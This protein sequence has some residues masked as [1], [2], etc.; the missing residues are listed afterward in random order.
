MD[1]D[2]AARTWIEAWDRAWRTLDP[3]PLRPVY[4]EN[5]VHHSHPFREPGSPL[6]YA[7]WAFSDEEGEPELW[8]GEPIVAGDRAV[9]EWWAVSRVPA[10]LTS[11]AGTSWLRFSPD[12]RVVEQHDYWGEGPGRTPPWEVWGR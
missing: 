11:L 10:G 2:A 1:P 8:W 3:E 9:V 7:A 5:A 12:G 6:D 4:A